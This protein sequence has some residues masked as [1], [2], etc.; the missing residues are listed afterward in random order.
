M[1]TA[2]PPRRS[3]PDHE[4]RRRAVLVAARP[5]L[6]QAGSAPSPRRRH[7]DGFQGDGRHI[8]RIITSG[9]MTAPAGA[10]HGPP[11]LEPS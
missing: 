6:Q 2:S 1:G 7:A 3:A 10:R 11:P 5:H 8:Q 4:H 9:V